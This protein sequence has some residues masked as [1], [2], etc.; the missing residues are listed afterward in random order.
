[1]AQTENK[2]GGELQ[3]RL[4]KIKIVGYIE[5]YHKLAHFFRDAKI[6]CYNI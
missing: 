1:M 4:Q 3:S 5:L 6:L 2:A